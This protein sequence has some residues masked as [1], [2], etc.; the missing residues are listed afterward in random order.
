[1]SAAALETQRDAAIAALDAKDYAG[2]IRAAMAA[3]LILAT[4]PS[5]S[6]ATGGGSQSLSWD[7][8]SIDRFIA[9]CRQLATDAAVAAGGIRQTKL[10][11]RRPDAT[12]LYE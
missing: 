3:K 10:T 11:L 12:G 8:A 1:M 9:Q 4:M 5:T 7:A 2:A 6:R